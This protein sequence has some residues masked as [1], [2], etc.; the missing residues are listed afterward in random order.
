MD[1]SV[2]RR[3]V[4][5]WSLALMGGG[6]LAAC[7]QPQA[8]AAPAPTQ[9]AVPTPQPVPTVPAQAQAPV[10]AAPKSIS[11]RFNWTYKGEF[12]PFF[13]AQEKGFYRDAGLQVELG[14]GKSGTQA[15]QVVA[16]G[17]DQFGYVPSVQVVQ[18]ITQGM[19]VK[20]IATLGKTTGM[21]WAAWPDIPLDGAKSLEGHKVSISTAS[22]F[23][24]VWD[25]FARKFG[26]DESK[27]DAVNVDPSARVGLFLS[28][29]V[30]IMA[31]I[32]TANDLVIVQNRA[33]EQLNVLKVADLNFDPLGYMLVANQ[34]VINS[35]SGLVKAFVSATL[36]GFSAMLDNPADATAIMVRLYGDRLGADVLDGQIKNLIPMVVSKPVLGR[37]DAAAWQQTLQLLQDA[38]VIDKPLP[39]ETYMTNDFV[40]G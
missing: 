39:L 1:G 36:K 10:V 35:D 32:F 25:A 33:P 21:C 26:V 30:D 3:T 11:I 9:P 28:R 14:E 29:Q 27:V 4:I 15:M 40:S 38:G 31:D 34:S 6:L 2:S 16:A 22:T 7:T 19:P 24:Q 20:S 17:N 37:V 8:P 12:T 18:G 5:S 13:V 23:F